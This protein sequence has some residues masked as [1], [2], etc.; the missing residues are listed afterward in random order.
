MFFKDKEE[1]I[2]SLNLELTG[3]CVCEH[4]FNLGLGVQSS[5]D[6][7]CF[8]FLKTLNSKIKCYS[9]A[10]NLYIHPLIG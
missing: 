6:L 8:I 4:E 3:K 5:L 2:I 1:K 7:F 10:T 9:G